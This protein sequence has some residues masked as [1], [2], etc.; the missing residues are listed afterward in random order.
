MQQTGFFTHRACS[1]HEM[2]SWHP[3][4]PERLAAISD[5]LISTGIAPHLKY[6]DAPLASTQD[7]AACAQ[8]RLHRTLEV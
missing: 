5:H 1:L 3:E 8:L 2:G 4:C 6:F 7:V